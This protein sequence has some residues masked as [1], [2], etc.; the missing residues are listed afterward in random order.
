MDNRQHAIP[1]ASIDA[2]VIRLGELA[3]FANLLSNEDAAGA[4]GQLD[5]A[6]QVSI[7][8]ALEGMANAARAALTQGA[9]VTHE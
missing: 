3:A 2:A 1:A 9:E 5:L 6:E 7:F 4:F 8:G